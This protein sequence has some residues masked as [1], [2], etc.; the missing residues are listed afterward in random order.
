[1]R[2]WNLGTE[3]GGDMVGGIEKTLTGTEVN[4]RSQAVGYSAVDRNALREIARSKQPLYPRQCAGGVPGFGA[5][6]RRSRRV[7]SF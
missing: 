1:M 3:H 7:L 6:R 5:G 4:C 2:V